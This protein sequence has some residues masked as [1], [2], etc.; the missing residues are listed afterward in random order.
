[1]NM[2]ATKKL[3]ELFEVSWLMMRQNP[4]GYSPYLQKH[5]LGFNGIIDISDANAGSAGVKI[6]VGNGQVHTIEPVFTAPDLASLTPTK[7]KEALNS[8]L[9]SEEIDDCTFDVDTDTERLM[10]KASDSGVRFIQIYGDLAAALQFGDCRF[11]EG[12]GCYLLASMDGDLKS[13][14]ETENWEEDKK[15]ENETSFGSKVTYTV[16]GRRESTQIVVSDRIASREAKQM[17]NGGKLY[18]ESQNGPEIYEPPV[19]S[20]HL[21]GKVDVFTYSKIMDKDESVEGDEAYVRERVY[22]GGL[23][24]MVRTGGAGSWID[25]EYTLTFNTYMDDSNEEHAS[26][27]EADYTK[28][29]W[30]SLGL[31]GVIVDDWEHA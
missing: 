3:R 27:R 16:R 1:M 21:P 5:L 2:I 9:E 19:A 31:S 22:I 14:S 20:G 29:Q 26:P 23:G 24:R 6:R 28:S 12:K 13:V 8:A 10:L 17:L 7:A 18:K 25:S 30:D 15:I 11:R 4:G